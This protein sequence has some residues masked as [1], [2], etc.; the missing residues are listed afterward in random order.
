MTDGMMRNQ[1]SEEEQIVWL[2]MKLGQDAAGRKGSAKWWW[3]VGD[4]SE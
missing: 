1:E 3:A 4:H 2:V